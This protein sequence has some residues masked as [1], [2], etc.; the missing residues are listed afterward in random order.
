MN[1]QRILAHFQESADF[2]LRSAL[3]WKWAR[4]R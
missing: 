2:I 1:T 4:M 3:S